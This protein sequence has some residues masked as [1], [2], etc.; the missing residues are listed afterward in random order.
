M[1][2]FERLGTSSEFMDLCFED[3]SYRRS[4]FLPMSD[5]E[6]SKI[7]AVVNERLVEA[8]SN[9]SDGDEE[10]PFITIEIQFDHEIGIDPLV[11]ITSHNKGDVIDAVICEEGNE[12]KV[13]LIEAS[14]FP[15]TSHLT[16]VAGQYGECTSWGFFHM[17][18]GRA[19]PLQPDPEWQSDSELVEATEFWNNHGFLATREE[20]DACLMNQPADENNF[21]APETGF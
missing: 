13:K 2:D 18:P 8:H 20:I 10:A 4:K 19:V 11:E 15:Q 5:D 14:D 16:V 1:L 12:G 9:L 7:I 3:V 6:K 21:D 17:Y